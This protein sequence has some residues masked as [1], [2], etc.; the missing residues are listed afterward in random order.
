MSGELV[1]GGLAVLIGVLG[2]LLSNRDAKQAREIELLFEKHDE[3]AK[4]LEALKLEIAKEH[5]L[6]HEL[7]SRFHQLDTTFR[8]GFACLS[9]EFKELTR[10]LVSHIAREESR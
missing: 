7:D 3:D 8:E 9:A 10:V 4:A 5:Y 2:W 6:K 1:T